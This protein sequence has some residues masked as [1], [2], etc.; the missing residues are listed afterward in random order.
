MDNVAP[1]NYNDRTESQALVRLEQL[2]EDLFNGKTIT[3][4]P[5]IL[6]TLKEFANEE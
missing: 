6:Y 4:I 3:N 1:V 5:M 2:K